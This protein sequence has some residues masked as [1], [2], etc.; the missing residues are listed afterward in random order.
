[1]NSNL[2][3]RTSFYVMLSAATAILCGEATDSRLDGFLPIIVTVAGVV[4]FLM[5]DRSEQWGIPR[6][7][8][9]ILA[10]GTLG[11]LFVEWRADESQPIHALG[12]WLVY[13]Q[14][15]WYFLPKKTRDD[16]I[17]FMLGLTQV[18][19][20]SVVNTG[21][22]VGVWLFLWAMLA[23]WVLG[24]F[25]LQREARRFSDQARVVAVA[26]PG[27]DPY[28]GLFDLPFLAASLR[29]LTLTLVLGGVFFL[30]LPRHVGGTRA[31]TA[32]TMTKHLT[33]FD[34][35]VKLGQLGEILKNDSVVMSVEFTDE[36]D[37]SISPTGEPLWRGVTLNSYE[38][39]RWRKRFQH[40]RQLIESLKTFKNDPDHPKTVIHQTIKLEANDSPTLFAIRPILGIWAAATNRLPPDLSPVDGTIFRPEPRGPYD[41][42]VLSDTDPESPQDGE[43]PPSE[44][45][46][47]VLSGMDADLKAQLAQIALP[48]V[49]DLPAKGA[50][51]ITA[52]AHAWRPISAIPA[53][54]ATPWR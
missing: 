29:V 32:G 27:A 23:V 50:E 9:D 34:E 41:Y 33:G 3:Y 22:L 54:S 17:L 48:V 20:G 28:L 19:I 21:D 24:L 44:E 53:N 35:E 15:I 6:D 42:V 51:G 36:S 39:G 18:L 7:V 45:G 31:R 38:K 12:H 37:R 25:F 49:K 46:I 14:L 13:F 5:V 40:S 1:M 16:W 4:A 43:L 26:S 30:M 8:A 52:R 11:I 47:K 2:I 10:L